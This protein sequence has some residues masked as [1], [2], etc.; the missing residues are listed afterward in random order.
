VPGASTI[1]A[2]STAPTG[3]DSPVSSVVPDAAV[4]TDPGGSVPVEGDDPSDEG[5]LPSDDPTARL[6]AYVDYTCGGSLNNPGPPATQPFDDIA[7][8]N[9][10]S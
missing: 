7:P 4:D 10:E 3:D 9:T 1:P 2:A 8:P 6:S 5:Y